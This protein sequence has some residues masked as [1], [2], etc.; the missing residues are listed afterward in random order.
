MFGLPR[1]RWTTPVIH[2][3]AARRWSSGW[4]RASPTCPSSPDRRRP[5]LPGRR[6]GEPLLRRRGLPVPP[7]RPASGGAAL[8]DR[9]PGLR[10]APRAGQPRRGL[11]R[12][13]HR[14]PRVGVEAGRPPRRRLVVRPRG[15]PRPLRGA[16]SSASTWPCCGGATRTRP[17]PGPGRGRRDHAGRRW[18]SGADASSPCAG[19]LAIALARP[20]A[21]ARVGPGRLAR[22]PEGTLVR[23]GPGV[24]PGG[25]PGHRR[26]GQRPGPPSGQRHRRRRSRGRWW[27]GCTPGP[28]GS[29]TA[30]CDGGRAG[31]GRLPGPRRRP[32]RRL[33]GPDLRLLLRSPLLRPGDRRPGRRHRAGG[34]RR[35]ATCPG[36]P[37]RE[38]DPDVGLQAEV[39]PVDGGAWHL[40]VSARRFAQYV[41][42]DVPG[43]VADDSWFHL[44]PGGTRT[45]VLRP[46][47]GAPEAPRGWVR[48]LN[49]AVPGAVTA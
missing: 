19:F 12:R 29:R 14:R 6:R 41:Q 16:C 18:P 20:A 40:Q 17:R 31:P 49:S 46:W 10:R 30:S 11:R 42:V 27:S 4:P 37:A 28:T 32:V 39:E 48:A 21:R 7:E 23:A 36:G 45:T 35:P 2:D 38:P 44:P 8:R 13:P 5:A 3:G 22:T 25:R 43:Y 15:R 24:D 1:E 47:P 33:P 26:G 9:G 34:G